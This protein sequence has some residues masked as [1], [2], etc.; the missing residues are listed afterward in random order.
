MK[1]PVKRKVKKVCPKC[2][3]DEMAFD[4]A[5]KWDETT[6]SYDISTVYDNEPTC[7]DCGEENEPKILDANTGEELKQ[8]PY[9]QGYFLPI[10]QAEREWEGLRETNRMIAEAAK[11]DRHFVDVANMM[12]PFDEG[13]TN[14]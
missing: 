5:V 8:G 1:K 4:A 2:G 9:F 10:E 3:S 13:G 12:T 11:I 6:Q 14:A 7:G